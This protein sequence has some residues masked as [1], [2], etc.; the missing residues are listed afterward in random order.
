MQCHVYDALDCT[1]HYCAAEQVQRYLAISLG[2]DART[3]SAEYQVGP[4]GEPLE[5]VLDTDAARRMAMS[6]CLFPN[7]RWPFTLI[8]GYTN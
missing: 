2:G 3:V 5:E 7:F 4:D 8:L 6:R 1:L